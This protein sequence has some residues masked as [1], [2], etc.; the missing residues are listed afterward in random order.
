MSDMAHWGAAAWQR[1]SRKRRP[2]GD[3][4]QDVDADE[5]H[6][7]RRRRGHDRG[8]A[9]P[10]RRDQKQRAVQS[11][12]AR[13]TVHEPAR[14]PRPLLAPAALRKTTLHLRPR[15][16]ASLSYFLARIATVRQA[17]S[18][19]DLRGHRAAKAS[20]WTA[21]SE[22]QTAVEPGINALAKLA[23]LARFAGHDLC[24]WRREPDRKINLGEGLDCHTQN[25]DLS[26]CPARPC[27][28]SSRDRDGPVVQYDR[29]IAVAKDCPTVENMSQTHFASAREH[30]R[31]GSRPAE[32]AP[33]CAASHILVGRPG[34]TS[35]V[36][37]GR[38]AW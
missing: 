11:A 33:R 14:S 5:R 34:A 38:V 19:V 35:R 13:E 28:T 21:T 12:R 25:A 8:Q 36:Y 31:T 3:W 29:E 2:R 15:T 6:A 17:R 24:Q 4:R 22:H 20:D 32:R 10:E 26:D 23:L 9:R 27:V 30:R 16:P 1:R 18:Q 7:R 37:P